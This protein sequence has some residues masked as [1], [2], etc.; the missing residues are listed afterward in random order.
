MHSSFESLS[1]L[2][3]FQT[4]GN[5]FERNN[6]ELLK[7][8]CSKVLFNLQNLARIYLNAYLKIKEWVELLP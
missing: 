6:V 8:C 3:N 2:Q 7:S 5:Y 4:S 1:V